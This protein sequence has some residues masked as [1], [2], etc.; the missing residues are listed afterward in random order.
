MAASTTMPTRTDI[1]VFIVILLGCIRGRDTCRPHMWDSSL[2]CVWLGLLQ[3]ARTCDKPHALMHNA[4]GQNDP[5]GTERPLTMRSRA[6]HGAA[7]QQ[8]APAAPEPR[9]MPAAGSAGGKCHPAEVAPYGLLRGRGGHTSADSRY[10]CR[11]EQARGRERCQCMGLDPPEP[12]A[13]VRTGEGI[14]VR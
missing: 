13:Q 4:Y 1:S 9:P 7:D 14:D 3:V 6:T 11:P 12:P 8:G 5:A 10:G 2:V